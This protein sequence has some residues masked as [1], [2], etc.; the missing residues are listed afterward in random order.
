[1]RT[2]STVIIKISRSIDRVHL[3]NCSRGQDSNQSN[4]GPPEPE[5]VNH[6]CGNITRKQSERKTNCKQNL[7]VFQKSGFLEENS[8]L[9]GVE[10]RNTSRPRE[11]VRGSRKRDLIA[12]PTEQKVYNV[13]MWISPVRVN[14]LTLALGRRLK[15]HH[16][17]HGVASQ[18]LFR[19]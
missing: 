2:Q 10:R 3:L 16:T 7:S 13:N 9:G 1:M 19:S 5:G 4:Q 12:L 14:A 17:R 15:S 8:C 11:G 18:T 6:F